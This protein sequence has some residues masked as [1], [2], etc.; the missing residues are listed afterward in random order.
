VIR[1]Q[2]ILRGQETVIRARVVLVLAWLLAWGGIGT[3]IG[4]SVTLAWDPN[5]EPDLAGY[6]LY[7]GVASRTYDHTLEVIGDTQVSVDGLEL[8][9][10]YYFAVTAHNTA[11]LESDYSNE[12]SYTVEAQSDNR[13]P[14]A[15]NLDLVVTANQS[16]PVTLD[17]FDPDADSLSYSVV[18]GPLHGAI[19]GSA[20]LLTYLP[21]TGFVGVDGFS[22][23]V[24]DGLLTSAPAEVNITV[25]EDPN[26][27]PSDTPPTIVDAQYLGYGLVLTWTS[28]PG[29][30]YRIL[31]KDGFEAVSWT[32]ISEEILAA[33]LRTS[34]LDPVAATVGGR[35][36]RVEL[37]G[38]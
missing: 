20:P 37:V 4:E 1:N 21:Q 35:L 34:W 25:T 16:V 9:T 36:Y 31:V 38:L 11:G 10:T 18:A 29:A 8:G 12:V 33:G 22:Y 14:F 23:T 7:Y 32:P 5:S 2:R 26:P 19:S 30:S 24:T 6:R 28:E 15:L 17:G 27:S 3:V 13:P